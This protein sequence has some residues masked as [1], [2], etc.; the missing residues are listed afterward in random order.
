MDKKPDKPEP[1]DAKT[2]LVSPYPI[3]HNPIKYSND[4]FPPPPKLV[5]QRA[6]YHPDDEIIDMLLS[7][8]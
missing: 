6:I 5:R 3:W 1:K 8:D 4:N 7:L 2:P